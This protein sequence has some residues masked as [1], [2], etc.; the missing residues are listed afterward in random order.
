[1]LEDWKDGSHGLA[2]V[3]KM[4]IGMIELELSG[5]GQD[6]LSGCLI[7]LGLAFVVM[8]FSVW[9]FWLG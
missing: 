1:M 6:P 8:S 4:R 9:Y 5:Y 2:T 3:Y 7:I